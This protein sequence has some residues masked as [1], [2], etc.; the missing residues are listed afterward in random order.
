RDVG[1]ILGLVL[2]AIGII[3]AT[4]QMLPRFD[5]FGAPLLL[6]G[7]GLAILFL[8]G[9]GD[10]GDQHPLDPPT[11]RHDR[12]ETPVQP[13]TPRATPAETAA[14]FSESS[15]AGPTTEPTTEPPTAP[16]TGPE[17][18]ETAPGEAEDTGTEPSGTGNVPPS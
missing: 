8:R 1:M 6:I 15:D 14:P 9:R 16:R 10:N 18:P 13:E 3:V 2:V 7:G 11:D 17:L 12:D 4:T 5:D